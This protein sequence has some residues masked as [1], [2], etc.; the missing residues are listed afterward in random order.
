MKQY[1]VNQLLLVTASL[2]YSQALEL[3]AVFYIRVKVFR[4]VVNIQGKFHDKNK[5]CKP[6]VIFRQTIKR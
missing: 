4:F 6:L 2:F 3:Y 5:S 1:V